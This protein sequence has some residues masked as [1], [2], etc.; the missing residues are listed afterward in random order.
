MNNLIHSPLETS[1][2]PKGLVEVS[3]RY[4][5]KIK[6]ESGTKK[7]APGTVSVVASSEIYLWLAPLDYPYRTFRVTRKFFEYQM[8]KGRITLLGPS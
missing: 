6:I 4:G 2:E 1:I 5:F 8:G 3:M 7:L